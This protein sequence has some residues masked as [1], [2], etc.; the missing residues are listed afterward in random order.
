MESF[1]RSGD[2]REFLLD[3][4]VQVFSPWATNCSVMDS[5]SWFDGQFDLALKD[6]RPKATTGFGAISRFGADVGTALGYDTITQEYDPVRVEFLRQ[7]VLQRLDRPKDADPILVFIKPE[8]HPIAKIREGR[9]RIIS[10]VGLVDTMVDRICLGWLQRAVLASVGKT[11]A[12]IGWSPYKGGSRLLTMRYGGRPAMSLDRS[13]WDWTVQG[14]LLELMKLMIAQLAVGAPRWWREWLELR[15]EVL[16]RDPIFGFRDGARVQ[17][18]GWG[19]MKS[20]CY[21]TIVLNSV[22]QVAM[23]LLA[24]RRLGWDDDLD[25]FFCM[26]DDTI[27]RE[28]CDLAK[29]TEQLSSM[30]AILKEPYISS[31][32]EF[33]G[34]VM[35]GISLVPHY[36]AKHVFKILTAPKEMIPEMLQAYQW[37]YADDPQMW[38]WLSQ[39]LRELAP[40]QCRTLHQ[41]RSLLRDG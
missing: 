1:L 4:L 31:K 3:R 35:Q 25:E 14:W 20:G 36:K 16:F 7:M 12:L 26:G 15:W 32:Y 5:E 37:C 30:G 27:Q 13:S 19:V 18:P 23:H 29:Y 38:A 8:P 24:C 39:M 41:A 40:W 28:V 6:L 10:A 17:Q 11:P 2:E 21:L 22:A 9:L 34:H 33:C